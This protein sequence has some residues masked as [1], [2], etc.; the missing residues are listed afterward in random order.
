MTIVCVRHG[1][2]EWSRTHRHTGWQD[3]PLNDTGREQA[4]AAR[5]RLAGRAFAVVLSSPLGRAR[6]T[7]L[8]AGFPDPEPDDDLREWNYGDAEGRT[9]EEMGDGWD[10]W[11]DGGPDGETLADVAARA[12]RV[13]ARLDKIEGDVI[14]FA[15]GHLLRVLA[16][17][18]I[19][20]PAELAQRLAL[21][22]AT[23]S[24]LD[25]SR[26]GVRVISRWNT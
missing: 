10:L 20:Q 19:D 14:L 24:E 23:I 7:A 26:L 22:N 6:E 5:E 17:R 12:D 15:H 16:T 13:V 3:I 8:L 18:W 25:S 21:G 11:R 2:T 4:R 9:A 1:E